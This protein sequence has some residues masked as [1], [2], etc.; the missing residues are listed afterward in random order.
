MTR[1]IVDSTCDMPKELLER[2][3][4]A[5]L[6]LSVIIDDKLYLDGIDIQLDDV[7]RAIRAGKTPKTSQIQREAANELFT[8]MAKAGTIGFTWRSP[9]Q[10]RVRSTWPTRYARR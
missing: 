8:S 6:R 4:I 1:I 3:S 10:C 9:R 2:F 7:Y 5:V